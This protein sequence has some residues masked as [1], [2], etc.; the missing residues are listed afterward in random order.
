MEI[1]TGKE[2]F[3]EPL[4]LESG[5]ILSRFELVY[6][7]YGKLNS[8]ASNAIVICHALTGSHHA[9]GKYKND[10]KFGWWDNLIGDKKAIDTTKFFVIC[11][12]ILGS[13]FGSTNALSID[14]G[15]NKE[16]RLRFPVLV[17]SDVVKAQMKLFSR[18]GIKKAFAVIGGSLGGMQAL[19]FAIEFPKFAKNIIMLATTY[20]TKPWAIAFNKIAIYGIVNDPEFKNGYYDK[21]EISKNGLLGMSLGRMAGHI[22]F[23]SPDSMDD[24]FSR[25]YVD[26]D[27]VYELLGRYEV[28]RYMEYNGLNFTKRFDP[29]SYLYIA[30]MMNNFDCTRHYENLSAALD[31]IKANVMLISFK[32]DM[33][34]PPNL[35]KEMY[36]ELI[37]LNK[38]AEYV[39]IKSNYGHDAFLVQ[40]DKFEDYIKKVLK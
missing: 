36:D 34:F 20:A 24:K 7:S 17:V 16:Y 23:L 8:D 29:L 22:S 12:N 19:C 25:K 31:N 37:L 13:S 3:E 4:Y 5:R 15:T 11:I 21:N 6:E 33:L 30:K 1:K 2:S 27:G 9:A 35:M 40:T 32:G 18:L 28:D 39:C 38:K 10:N 26:T 14:P